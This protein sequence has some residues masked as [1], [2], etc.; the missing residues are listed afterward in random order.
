LA[1]GIGEW[2]SPGRYVGKK[3]WLAIVSRFGF[4][5]GV[6]NKLPTTQLEVKTLLNRIQHFV[7]FTHGCLMGDWGVSIMTNAP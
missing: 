4:E 3:K 2:L 7:G 6:K 5:S 1:Q